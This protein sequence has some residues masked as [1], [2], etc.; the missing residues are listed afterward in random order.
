VT[1]LCSL[2]LL[3]IADSGERKATFDSFDGSG[4]EIDGI[5]AA[6]AAI[7]FSFFTGK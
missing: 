1:E 2:Y 4:F 3:A 6:F 7:S 5:M